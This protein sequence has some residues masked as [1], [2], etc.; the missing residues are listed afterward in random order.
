MSCNRTHCGVW[1]AACHS[2][3]NTGCDTSADCCTTCGL[4]TSNLDISATNPNGSVQSS[5]ICGCGAVLSDADCC[6]TCGLTINADGSAIR[7]PAPPRPRHRIGCYTSCGCRRRR[8]RPR[9]VPC[10]NAAQTDSPCPRHHHCSHSA[11]VFHEE[12]EL[13]QIYAVDQ[14]LL[15]GTLYPELNKPFAAIRQCPCTAHASCQQL[16][17]FTLWEL[18]LYL[19]THPDDQRALALFQK[20]C[21]HADEGNYACAF[22]DDCDGHWHWLDDPWPWEHQDCGCGREG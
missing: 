12:Q 7:P 2:C 5:T 21:R 8:R 10:C 11:S 6:T 14:A 4:N 1:N 17:A 16:E 19:N 3:G 22:L 18:R 15:Q 9:P 20:L 13:C